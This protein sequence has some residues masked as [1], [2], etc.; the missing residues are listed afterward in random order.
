VNPVTA[1]MMNY[2]S[3]FGLINLAISAIMFFVAFSYGA[4]MTLFG[5]LEGFALVLFGTVIF[6]L[7]FLTAECL[8]FWFGR[9]DA[10]SSIWD[11]L[12]Q[13]S[14]YPVV[15]YPQAMQFIF[16]F[17]MP[18]IFVQTYPAMFSM[19]MGFELF[20]MTVAFELFLIAVWYL[21]FRFFWNKGLKRYSSYGG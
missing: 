11:S 4:Q 13:S 15:I 1:H 7:I 19:G 18:L 2:I 17:V 12:W 14:D 20:G 16:T 6:S 3:L 10:I 9:T 8:S 21:I 5:F